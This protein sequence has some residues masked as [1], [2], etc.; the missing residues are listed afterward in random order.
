M[1]TFYFYYMPK[2]EIV[3]K[4]SNTRIFEVVATDDVE[5]EKTYRRGECKEVEWEKPNTEDKKLGA[6][7]LPKHIQALVE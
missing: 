5:A 4:K 3:Y 6:K 1:T 7:R 2:G